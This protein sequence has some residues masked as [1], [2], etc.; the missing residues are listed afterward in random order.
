MRK[1]VDGIDHTSENADA[2]EVLVAIA[3]CFQ[4][5]CTAGNSMID[6]LDGC[7]ISGFFSF[8]EQRP[9]QAVTILH[10][11]RRVTQVELPHGFH[12]INYPGNYRK[13][14]NTQQKSS[15]GTGL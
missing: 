9:V 3:C 1:P 11:N 6:I 12:G 7:G 4:N 15:R 14:S 8:H 13:S 2:P 5:D 10:S